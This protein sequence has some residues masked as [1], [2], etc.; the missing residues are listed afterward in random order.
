MSAVAGRILLIS[1]G[2]Y[3]AN[4]VYNSLDW[5]RYNSA[6]WVCK[7]DNT[8][9]EPPSTSSTKWALM[10]ADSAYSSLGDLNDVTISS[11]A[12]GQYLGVV[13]DTSVMEFQL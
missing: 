4:T 9:N 13:I 6:A 11:E 8:Q 5:V 1:K 10:A 2:D 12:A 3:N 7:A